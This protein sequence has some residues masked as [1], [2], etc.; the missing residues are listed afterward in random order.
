MDAGI[1]E[2][3]PH[4][5]CPTWSAHQGCLYILRWGDALTRGQGEGVISRWTAASVRVVRIRARVDQPVSSRP[6]DRERETWTCA[7][8]VVVRLVLVQLV[9]TFVTFSVYFNQEIQ[10]PKIFPSRIE[11]LFVLRDRDQCLLDEPWHW[12]TLYSYLVIFSP[13]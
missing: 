10:D 7:V 13:I 1:K 9:P 12:A 11:L 6:R 8:F 3:C 2:G 5:P 4:A